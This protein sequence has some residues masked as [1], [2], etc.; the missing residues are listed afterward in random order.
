MGHISTDSKI[1]I[2]P[3]KGKTVSIDCAHSKIF[4]PLNTNQY[5]SKLQYNF[6]QLKNLLK[7]TYPVLSE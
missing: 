2:C 4:T 1:N 5:M 6:L 7:T 3:V